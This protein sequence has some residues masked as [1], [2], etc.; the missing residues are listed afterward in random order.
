MRPV[1]VT[2]TGLF[3]FLIGFF[4][5][6]S[7]LSL[8]LIDYSLE[9]AKEISEMLNESFGIEFNMDDFK[10]F[11]TT[12]GYFLA[13]SGFIYLLAGW[14]LFKLREWGRILTILVCGLNA[15]YGF[16]ASLVFPL[17]FFDVALNLVIIW[18]LMKIDVKKAFA[19]KKSIEERIL[20]R[21]IK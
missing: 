18:Y 5:L 8:I 21:D 2:L 19:T 4:G 10:N 17:I 9:E 7:G 16:F 20:G 15:A 3:M 1:G 13:F 11:Y 14:G 12:F 6:L